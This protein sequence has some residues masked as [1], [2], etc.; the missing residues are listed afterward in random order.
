[1]RRNTS[2][3]QLYPVIPIETVRPRRSESGS[4]LDSFGSPFVENQ[5][6]VPLLQIGEGKMNSRACGLFLDTIAGGVSFARKK[7]HSRRTSALRWWSLLPRAGIYLFPV[8][9]AK[10]SNRGVLGNTPSSSAEIGRVLFEEISSRL[11]NP[12][13]ERTLVC[14]VSRE[15]QSPD[16]RFRGGNPTD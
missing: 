11:A 3:A 5:P 13:R 9:A 7:N 8:V 4:G 15:R 10:T 6:R 1:M 14:S 12:M 16:W 2:Q